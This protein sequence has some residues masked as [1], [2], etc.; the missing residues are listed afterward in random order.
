MK[1]GFLEESEGVK[2]STRLVFVLGTLAVLTMTAIMVWRGTAPIDC[3][4]FL[5]MGIAALGGTKIAGAWQENK[6]IEKSDKTT[7]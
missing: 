6:T 1:T 3:G 5:T 2:S 7:A 4:T